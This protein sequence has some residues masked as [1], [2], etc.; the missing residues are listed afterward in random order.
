MSNKDVKIK[1]KKIKIKRALISVSDKRYLK[2]LAECLISNGVELISTG[3]SASFLRKRNISINEVSDVTGFPEMMDGRVKTLHPFIHGGILFRRDKVEHLRDIEYHGIMEIDLV[4]IN[5]YPF[6]NSVLSGKSYSECIENIDIGGPTLIRAA[7]KNYENVCVLVNPDDYQELIKGLNETS[8]TI[9]DSFRK[10]MALKAFRLVSDYDRDIH[11]WLARQSLEENVVQPRVRKEVKLR[12]GENPHQ[13][14]E[15]LIYDEEGPSIGSANQIQGKDM[16]YNNYIDSDSAF[17]IVSDFENKDE[18][19]CVIVKHKNPCG[20]AKASTLLE[21][22]MKANSSD[23]V[24]AFGGIIAVNSVLDEETAIQMSK[25]YIEV[26]IAPRI[27]KKAQQIF[28]D[29]KNVRLLETSGLLSQ[30]NRKKVMKEI[31]GGILLQDENTIKFDKNELK[32]VTTLK[33]TELELDDLIFAWKVIRHV[34][35]NAI[36]IA[37]NGQ[38]IGIGN[39]QTSRLDSV[40]MAV[41]KAET[42]FRRFPSNLNG[43]VSASDAFFPFSDGIVELAKAG[44]KSVIQPGGSVNDQKIICEANEKKISMVFTG[45]RNFSH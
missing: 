37:K 31:S 23:P 43:T 35:S 42:F 27:S 13:E 3:G 38:T 4:V 7:A 30:K 34:A 39:G 18:F 1:T 20:V 45:K 25:T 19:V 6:R 9:S 33:P 24:S 12:Y 8:G 26:I 44:I 2:S 28:K 32:Y 36:I 15:L 29:K 41:E 11:N 21:A 10:K 14:A 5:L 22:Y 40:K 16:S 17:K